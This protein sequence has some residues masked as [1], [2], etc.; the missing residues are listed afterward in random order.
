[1]FLF[2][3]KPE[4]KFFKIDLSKIE[5]L[6]ELKAITFMLLRARPSGDGNYLHL[7]EKAFV[8]YPVLKNLLVE[9]S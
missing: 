4:Q 2:K 5:T 3:K 8:D 7:K 9:K 6:D 1:M